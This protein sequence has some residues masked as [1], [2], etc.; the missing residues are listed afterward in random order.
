[1]VEEWL[2]EE[3][4]ETTPW[5]VTISIDSSDFFASD[6]RKTGF[7]SSAAA[8]VA[9]VVA[10][11]SVAG[12][13]VGERMTLAQSLAIAAHRRAQNGVGSGYDVTASLNGGMGI[14]HGGESPSWKTHGF[15]WEATLLTFPGERA[16]VTTR[17]VQRYQEWKR[18]NPGPAREFLTDSNE[19]VNGFLSARS[20]E[21]AEPWF[22]KSRRLGIALGDSIGVPAV[23][24][25]PTGLDPDWCK[26]LGAGNEM[27]VCIV[28][29]MPPNDREATP[30]RRIIT[31]REGIRW[32]I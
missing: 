12:V 14:F 1:V 23:I 11:L 24:E 4:G 21:E 13:V 25:P 19:A 7:G 9:A 28:S 8:T 5:R 20:P 27:G 32:E 26:S 6:G 31:A 16:V 22:A 18:R 29:G 10:L 3:R 17:S 2:R 30:W 15:G